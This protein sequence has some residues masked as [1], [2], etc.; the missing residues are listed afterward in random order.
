MIKKIYLLYHTLKYLKIKQIIYRVYFIIKNLLISKFSHIYN[1]VYDHKVFNET[2]NVKS[3]Q[4][5]FSL[6]NYSVK[7]IEEKELNKQYLD[8]LNNKFIFLNE[9][10][11]FK[12]QIKW[13]TTKGSQLWKFNLHYFDYVLDLAIYY[14]LNK[15]KKVYLLFKELVSD[16]IENNYIGDGDSWHPYVI[17]LRIVN[18]IKA[19]QLFEEKIKS[20]DEFKDKFLT[21]IYKQSMF[22]SDNLEYHLGGNHLIENGK[23]LLFVGLFFEGKRA[24]KW[25]KKGKEILWKQLEEQILVDGGHYERSPMYHSIVLRDYLEVFLL[26]KRNDNDIPEFLINKL[27]KM[28]EF[29]VETS[30]PDKEISLFND[31]AFEIELSPK[32]LAAVGVVIFNRSDFKDFAEEFSLYAYLMLGEE[33]FQKFNELE[34]EKSDYSSTALAETGYYILRDNKNS[35]YLIFDCGPV[36]P[37]YN[38]GHAHADTLSFE[39]S[40]WGERLIVDS[41]VYGY[42][43]ESR[44]EF[45]STKAHNTVTIDNLDQSEVWSKFRVAKRAKAKEKKWINK[46]NI[47]IIQGEHDGYKRL[48]DSVIH[49]RTI[50]FVNNEYWII[51]DRLFGKA[52]HYIESNLHFNDNYNFNKISSNE[53]IISNKEQKNVLIKSITGQKLNPDQ[54]YISKEFGR[55]DLS[56]K[57]NLTYETNLPDLNGFI[58]YPFKKDIPQLEMVVSDDQGLKIKVKFDDYVDEIIIPKQNIKEEKFYSRIRR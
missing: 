46:D 33:G 7:N 54:T 4:F 42:H 23:T 9:T 28:F 19:Y 58:I 53:I 10:Q 25:F 14:S 31:S 22:L 5:I 6:G 15:D 16:W 36:G 27:E 3:N 38:P 49:E 12:E 13:K 11:S 24:K 1:K 52:I 26:L 2:I 56:N 40:V 47:V 44:N 50:C 45:R 39:L 30:H 57:L 55:K 37:D 20:D 8:L 51:V 34:K 41:G 21:S 18:W 48:K 43:C 35:K 17:S 32:E 29:M